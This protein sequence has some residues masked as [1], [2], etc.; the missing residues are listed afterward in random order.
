[1]F[2]KRSVPQR[3]NDGNLSICANIINIAAKAS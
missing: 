1:M 3:R 2:C